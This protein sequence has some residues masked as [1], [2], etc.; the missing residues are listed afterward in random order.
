MIYQLRKNEIRPRN[1]GTVMEGVLAV[2]LDRSIESLLS[3]FRDRFHIIMIMHL[4]LYPCLLVDGP[5][6]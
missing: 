5:T 1:Q 3:I 2:Y 4:L 6:R